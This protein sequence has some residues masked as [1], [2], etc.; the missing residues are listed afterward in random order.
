M[1]SLLNINNDCE[2]DAEERQKLLDA[3]IKYGNEMNNGRSLNK[4]RNSSSSR[5]HHQKFLVKLKK[6]SIFDLNIDLGKSSA[7][8]L[9]EI[10]KTLNSEFYLKAIKNLKFVAFERRPT[11]LTNENYRIQNLREL[12]ELKGINDYM[13]E[14][15]NL[16]RPYQEESHVQSKNS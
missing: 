6:K 2:W 16:K 1:R 5:Q 4:V 14:G 15:D 8:K 10:G 9:N 11:L 3:I 7:K 13:E 12:N